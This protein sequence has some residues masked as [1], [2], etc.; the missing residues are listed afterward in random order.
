MTTPL[1]RTDRSRLAQWWWTIDRGSVFAIFALIAMGVLLSLSSSPA[2]SVRV[3]VH[4]PFYFFFRQAIYASASVVV[5][6]VVSNLS[7]RGV[8]RLAA[9]MFVCAIIAMVATLFF[10][11]SAKGAQRWIV[12]G[13]F[14]LQ[15][16]EFMKPALIILAAWMFSERAKGEGFPG[17]TIAFG[18]Y[19]LAVILL[20]LQPDFGQTVLITAAFGATFFLA[21]VPII[22]IA[23]MALLAAVG[24]WGAYH[25]FP[26]VA[27]RVDMFLNPASA[28]T[29]QIDRAFN[30]IAE[31]GL[32]GRGPGEGAVKHLLPDSHT[33]FI[34]AVA[35]EEFGLFMSL[36]LIALMAVVVVRGLVRTMRLADQFEQLAAA[37]LFILFGLQAFINFSV[38]LRLVP[39][40]GMTLPLI[41]YGGSSMLAVALTL[42]L[43]LALTRRRPGAFEHTAG[44]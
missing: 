38:N 41:S 40:K 2:A 10:G 39:P 18:L 36:T 32:L 17:V 21:G 4:D 43:A 11:H 29:Y 34:Y 16:S 12:I 37:G 19:G 20:M 8:R 15:P 42:G 24:A 25:I 27:E 6:F 5:L 35:A 22:W 3:G 30:A 1:A 33:D 31:G 44:A 14:T 9:V 28:D 23:L 26:H 7:P 13:G